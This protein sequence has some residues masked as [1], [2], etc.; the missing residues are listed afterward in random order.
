MLIVN[1]DVRMS[2]GLITAY[3]DHFSLCPVVVLRSGASVPEP[4]LAIGRSDGA[5]ELWDTKTWHLH[6]TTLGSIQSAVGV[7]WE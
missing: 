6:S 3:R 4:R 2:S 5:L 1:S 7:D